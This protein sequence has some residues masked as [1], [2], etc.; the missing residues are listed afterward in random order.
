MKEPIINHF[1]NYEF[2]YVFLFCSII[3]LLLSIFI[4]KNVIKKISLFSFSVFFVL[5][6]FELILSVLMPSANTFFDSCYL[7]T[8]DITD[9]SQI[10]E[11]KLLSSDNKIYDK[12]YEFQI[13][14]VD[15]TGFGDCKVIFDKI[16]SRYSNKFRVTKCDIYSKDCYVF[17]GCSYVFGLG[18]SDDETLPYYFSKDFNFE[19]NIINCGIIGKATN[20]LLNILN[21]GVF[22]SSIQETAKVKRFFYFLIRDHIYRNFR[23]E[24][25]SQTIDGY[26][27]KNNKRYVPT[28]IGKIKYIFARS[29][30][31]RKVFVPVIDEV[32]R[33]YYEDY[34]IE[35]L[36]EMNKITEEKYNSKL[37][38]VV[39]PDS[40]G[41]KFIRKLK[42]ANL[43]LIF[44][45]E[46][47]NSEEKGY[48][49]KNEGH[50][51]AKANKEI[52]E[53]LYNHIK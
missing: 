20:I 32:F 46:E 47:F 16:Y 9:I 38:I 26:L 14:D 10:R 23:Y 13:D 45:S 42:E 27:Y 24:C 41:E 4:K 33:E 52:A 7:N 48:K 15:L 29:Y 17:L 30:I 12:R 40:Y 34:M 37:T 50:P 43:D 44:L 28:V 3:F 49:I 6:C 39:W 51:T 8:Y 2:I 21:N 5:F 35:S 11:I 36:K 22:E 18:V 31:F 1:L 53:I 25:Q 19:K